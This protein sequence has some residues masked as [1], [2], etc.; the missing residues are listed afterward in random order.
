MAANSLAQRIV[1]SLDKTYEFD[2]EPVPE[3]KLQPGRYFAWT[4]AGEH[5]A[6]TEFVIG[7]LFV[8]WGPP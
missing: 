4:F 6:G 5:T 2:R 7:A 3:H 8:S 1:A